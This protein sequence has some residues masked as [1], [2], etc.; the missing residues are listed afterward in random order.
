MRKRDKLKAI[1]EA[2]Q[3]LEE[4]WYHTLA[5]TAALL[6]SSQGELKAQNQQDYK[7][8][9]IE[10]VTETKAQK[11]IKAM[12][13]I[14]QDNTIPSVYVVGKSPDIATAKKIALMNAKQE[15]IKKYKENKDIF[16]Q[17]K[18]AIT[19]VTEQDLIVVVDVSRPSLVMGNLIRDLI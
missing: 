8:H 3:R 5:T 17:S 14:G 2:N 9:E 19:Q 18:D 7:S 15:F 12:M 4:K 16:I 11:E 10:Q 13:V 6:A 1:N